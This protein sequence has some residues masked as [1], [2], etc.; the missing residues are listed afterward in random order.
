MRHSLLLSS[1]AL[2][3]MTQ[4]VWAQTDTTSASSDEMV[5]KLITM[6]T[7]DPVMMEAP[8]PD[9]VLMQGGNGYEYPAV[10]AKLSYALMPFSYEKVK[11]DFEKK[12][13]PDQDGTEILSAGNKKLGDWEGIMMTMRMTPPDSV[14]FGVF[15]S[16]IYVVPIANGDQCIMF[17]AAYPEDMKDELEAPI[18]KAIRK[19]KVR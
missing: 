17:A 3:L 9:F 11:E 6:M 1:I 8:T 16:L 7:A 15:L 2:F 18:L 10:Q 19:A 4:G 12:P 14:E 13:Q 5:Q